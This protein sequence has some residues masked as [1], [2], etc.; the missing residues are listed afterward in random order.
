VSQRANRLIIRF[1]VAGE[2]GGGL[3]GARPTLHR[4]D[5]SLAQSTRTDVGRSTTEKKGAPVD[6]FTAQGR[7]FAKQDQYD[8]AAEAYERALAFYRE[9][10]SVAGVGDTLNDLG[11][12]YYALGRY[13]KAIAYGERALAMMRSISNHEGEAGALNLLGATY[14]ELGSYDKAIEYYQQALTVVR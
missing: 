8:K 2:S 13:E 5:S 12:T 11:W 1:G 14:H 4:P 6:D 3:I 7:A 9:Q 10:G